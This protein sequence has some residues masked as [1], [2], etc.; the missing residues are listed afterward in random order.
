MRA[1]VSSVGDVIGMGHEIGESVI[2]DA[3][4]FGAADKLDTPGAFVFVLQAPNTKHHATSADRDSAFANSEDPPASFLNSQ[5]HSFP[6]NSRRRFPTHVVYHP[7]K[8]A[9]FVNDAIRHFA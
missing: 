5:M 4:A 8:S 2:A 1:D 3:T 7:I 6:L 9:H